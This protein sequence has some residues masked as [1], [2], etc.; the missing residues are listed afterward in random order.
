[1]TWRVTIADNFHYM[2]ESEHVSGGEFATYEDALARAKKIVDDSLWDTW[3]AGDTPDA[4][5]ARYVMFGRRPLHRAG[6]RAAVFGTRPRAFTRRG[7]L[8][9]ARRLVAG[10]VDA[11]T[12]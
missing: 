4:L 7:H 9:R 1:M 3:Q 11:L 2:D 10:A 12:G 5:M 8:P 6:G